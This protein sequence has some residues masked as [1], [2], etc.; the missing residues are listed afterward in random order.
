MIIPISPLV[1]KTNT[2]ERLDVSRIFTY[3]DIIYSCE[4]HGKCPTPT[5]VGK[6]NPECWKRYSLM[7]D[8]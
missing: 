1:R 3:D 4:H 6:C 2:N 8:K 5:Y 7:Y